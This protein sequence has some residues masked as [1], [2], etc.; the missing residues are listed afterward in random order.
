MHAIAGDID[1][2]TPVLGR[3]AG[4]VEFSL[5]RSP[6]GRGLSLPFARLHGDPDEIALR[7]E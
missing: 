2:A 7:E 5:I 4:I 3:D 1:V 6:V